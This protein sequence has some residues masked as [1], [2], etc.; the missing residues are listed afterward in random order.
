MIRYIVKITY[1]LR[2]LG[3]LL[4]CVFTHFAVILHCF[5][6][7]HKV[8]ICTSLPSIS[9]SM[10]ELDYFEVQKCMPCLTLCILLDSSY[11]SDTM[12]LG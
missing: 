1:A 10:Q 4:T 9:R 6:Y 8:S 5:E 2:L 3:S 12:S 11:W 7:V